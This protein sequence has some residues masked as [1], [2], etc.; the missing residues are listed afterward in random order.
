MFSEPK[1]KEEKHINHLYILA[2][3]IEEEKVPYIIIKQLLSKNI[4]FD[5]KCELLDK[6]IPTILSSLCSTDINHLSRCIEFNP[7]ENRINKLC[8]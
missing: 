6:T 2:L 7:N 1:T 4:S 5:Y 3:L 8:E